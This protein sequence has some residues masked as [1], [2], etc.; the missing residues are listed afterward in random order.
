MFTATAAYLLS[1]YLS[2][3]VAKNIF[4][5]NELLAL[6]I[7][8]FIAAVIFQP[9]LKKYRDFIDETFHKTKYESDKIAKK[10]SDDIKKIMEVQDLASL[11]TRVAYVTFKLKG[12]AS[13]IYNEERKEYICLDARGG[14][15]DLKGIALKPDNSIVYRLKKDRKKIFKKDIADNREKEDFEKLG[16]DLIMPSISNRRDYSLIGFF[17][18]QGK[19]SSDPFTEEDLHLLSAFSSQAALSLENAFLYKK[20]ISALKKS[21]HLE[22]LAS[23]GGA[24]AGVA[25]SA[26]KALQNIK[27]IALEFK[28]KKND[29]EFL[30][31]TLRKLPI[32]VE[33]MNLLIQ[34]VLEFIK[35]TEKKEEIVN[36]KEA[37][38]K[39]VLLV[40]GKI[41]N[42]NIYFEISAD[43]SL[44]LRISSV[45]L[46]QILLNLLLNSIDAIGENGR[47]AITSEYKD[48]K[49]I[50][51]VADTG[52]G[53]L[54][55]KLDKIFEP[56]YTTKENSSG[57]GLSIVKRL[58]E[59]SGGT[60]L[61][62]SKIGEGT[63]FKK[64][65][66]SS[67]YPRSL[68]G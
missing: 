50:I 43:Q 3:E 64:V 40:E 28:K 65:F 37:I 36:V 18:S 48:T 27:A 15:K 57:L 53:I 4:K 26:E 44:H 23:L 17:V 46:K 30:N 5:T 55:D 38:E 16:I 49:T 34:G 54:P 62:E 14:M 41:K 22:K 8:V 2:G 59:E 33:R 9:F 61:V 20:N 66:H 31:E 13:F 35:P 12:C 58:I 6:S 32:E 42:R 11:V 19:K 10:F 63:R 39:T 25:N 24:A 56:Y 1:I 68:P 29:R 45:S 60:I 47:I 7:A 52:H 67:H 51:E 21:F